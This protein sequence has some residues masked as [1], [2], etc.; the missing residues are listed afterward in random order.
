[1]RAFTPAMGHRY[2]TR[3]NYD[4]GPGKH[5]SVSVLSP[6]IRRRLVTEQEVVAAALAAHGPQVAKTYVAQ[7]RLLRLSPAL[8]RDHRVANPEG[9]DSIYEVSYLPP[10]P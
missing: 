8:R 3:R 1:M 6:Y 9:L 7:S 5:A 10:R 4:H 2:A